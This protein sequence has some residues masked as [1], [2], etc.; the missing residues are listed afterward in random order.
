MRVKSNARKSACT[1][2]AVA[3]SSASVNRQQ[4]ARRASRA[5]SGAL[6]LWRV[7]GDHALLQSRLLNEDTAHALEVA[8]PPFVDQRA[9]HDRAQPSALAAA[10][11]G[12]RADDRLLG[13]A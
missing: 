8:A 10:L 9:A 3:S 4:A 5:P 7:R 1:V 13:R 2:H 6:S 11:G 12:G